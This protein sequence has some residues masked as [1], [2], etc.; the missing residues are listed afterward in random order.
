MTTRQPEATAASGRRC[1]HVPEAANV[2]TR[3]DHRRAHIRVSERFL[4]GA[5]VIPS[6][7]ARDLLQNDHEKTHGQEP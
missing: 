5:N 6:S 3:V 4:N 2:S 1:L 7:S